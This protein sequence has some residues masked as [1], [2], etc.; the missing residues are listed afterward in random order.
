MIVLDVLESNRLRENYISTFVN[1][2][3]RYYIDRRRLWI[4]LQSIHCAT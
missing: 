1:T 2:D 4:I 3:L